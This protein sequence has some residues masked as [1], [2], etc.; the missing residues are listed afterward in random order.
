[1]LLAVTTRGLEMILPLPSASSADSS[2]ARKR[3]AALLNRLTATLAGLVPLI[4]A[5][6]RLRNGPL[7]EVAPGSTLL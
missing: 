5:A 4:E 1:M 2:S 7:S 3:V 6:G